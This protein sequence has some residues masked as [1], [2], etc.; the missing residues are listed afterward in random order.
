MA[1]P[2]LPGFRAIT[3]AAVLA[4]GACSY[5]ANL[6]AFPEAEGFGRYT[7]GAR[8]ASAPTIYHVTNLNDSGAGSLRDAVSQPNRIVVFDVGGIINLQSTLIFSGNSIIAGQTAPGD[9]IM[10]YGDRVSF[11]GASNLIVR[12]L[13]IHMGVGGTS[14]KDAAGV[15]NGQNMIFDHVSVTW[16]RDETFSVNWDSKGTVPSNITIQN[17]IIG[18][19]LQTHSC[20]GLMQTDGGVTLFRNLYIDNKTRNPKVKGLNQFVNNVVYNW[21]GGGGYIMGGSSGDSWATIEDNYFIKGPSTGGTAAF[22]RATETFQ[23]Y[24]KNN[25]LDYDVDGNLDGVAADASVFSGAQAVSSA[26]VFSGAPQVHPEIRGRTSAE[27]AYQ[28]IVNGVGASYPARS[29][30]DKYIVAELASLGKKG[31]LISNESA[32]GLSGGVGKI[33]S[34]TKPT[35]SD[36]DGIP[37]AWETANGLNKNDASDALKTST[38]G[39]LNIELYINSL[40]SEVKSPMVSLQSGPA[41]QAVI[42]GDSIYSAIFAFKNCTGVSVSGLPSGL[43]YSTDATNGTVRIYGKPTAVGSTTFT[44]ST[45]GGTGNAAQ[46]TGTVTVVTATAPVPMPACFL[47]SVNA[48]FPY[49]GYGVYEEKNAGWIDS[50]YYNFTNTSSAYALWNLKA[51]NAGSAVLV[52]LFANGGAASRNM[53]LEVNGVDQGAV[54]FAAT[55]AW[56]T[57]D[58]TAVPITL[59]K[60]LNSIKLTSMGADGGPNIDQFLFDVA[61]V[62]LVRDTSTLDTSST[63]DPGVDD[64]TALHPGHVVSDSWSISRAGI[65]SSPVS[66]M[67]EI[68]IFDQRGRRIGRIPQYILAGETMLDMERAALPAGAYWLRISLGGHAVLKDRW[69]K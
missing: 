34:G 58:S 38:S 68:E 1:F 28:L 3:M 48:A 2:K 14:G 63:E 30:V 60:N 16:G 66:G 35:D 46:A 23:V 57:W 61:G 44:V 4:G 32:L 10:L 24:Q 11:S 13:R 29:E 9:G 54:A 42:Q 43:N 69:V 8:A 53:H 37:D 65:V 41:E 33:A 5:A 6:L 27:E 39:Y 31:T 15:A 22:V 62:E 20:G 7:L 12:Y 56:T 50:G 45:V 49:E 21:G 40:V 51:D 26:T 67:A 36:N 64:P 17:S 59:V 52:I 55:G 25:M 18:Q 47:S 19:G